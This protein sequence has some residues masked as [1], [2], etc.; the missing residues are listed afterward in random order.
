[1]SGTEHAQF[2]SG[3]ALR[4][5]DRT[6]LAVAVAVALV[7]L[8]ALP[9]TSDLSYIGVSWLMVAGLIGL[10]ALLRRLQLPEAAIVG[11]QLAAAALGSAALAA[12]LGTSAAT[13]PVPHYLGLWTAGIEHMQ[14]QTSPMAP[15]DGVR[16][17]FATVLALAAVVVDAL[18]NALGRPAWSLAPLAAVFAV[19]AVGLGIDTGIASFGCLVAGYAAILVA[20]GLN[21]TRRWP[22]GLIRDSAE[23]F[24]TATPVVW[25]ATAYLML[26][27]LALTVLLGVVLPTLTLPGIGIGPGSGSGGP[28]QLTDP[29]LDLRRNLT[30]SGDRVVIEYQTDAPGGVYLRLATLPRLSS[31]GWGSVPIQLRTGADLPPAPGVSRAI[32]QTPQS[33]SVQVLDFGS[34][35][36]PLPYA[37]THIEVRGDWR[38]DANSL[39][40]INND[41]RPN[42]LRHLAY[43]VES[44]AVDP[45]GEAFAGARPGSPDDADLTAEIPPDL[46]TS[47]IALTRQVT[48]D[49][50][51]PAARAAAIQ[52]FLRSSRFTYSTEQLP[53]TGYGALERF[54]LVDRRGFCEQF[55]GSM[56]MM[57]R[58]AGIPSRVSVGFLPGVR[59]DEGWKVSIRKMHAWPELYFEG[60]GWVRY[61]PTPS[62]VTGPAPRW[63]VDSG[64]GG[65]DEPSLAPTEQPSVEPSTATTDPDAQATAAPSQQ[66]GAAADVAR[67][68]VVVG[69]VV[70]VIALASAPALIRVRRRWRRL[71]RGKPAAEVVED[72]WEEIR[73]TVLDTGGSWP[74]GS[75]RA[76]GAELA[77]RL[78]PADGDRIAHVA[79]LV[80]RARYARGFSDDQAAA[81]VPAATGE[82]RRA[83]VAPLSRRRRISV[84]LLPRSVFRRPGGRAAG[85]SG[86]MPGHHRQRGSRRGNPPPRPE[87]RQAK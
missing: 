78:D 42:A 61:E 75:P 27:A 7:S 37:P 63:T 85:P 19:P 15:N 4:P 51:T 17:I 3:P 31:A 82:L 12:T 29:T 68:L 76:V 87:R 45:Q 47:L 6:A 30:Q 22:R 39:V 57:A 86:P 81:Q 59:D 10:G 55:A 73:D 84:A 64:G 62:L 25:R 5:T 46:P 14:T 38:F 58:V 67:I 40:V 23:G 8:T 56:A 26:P 71:D 70:L 44:A 80:E 21:R 16:L 34:Q 50:Q 69:A 66:P 54:L 52:A 32:T 48:A 24:G 41:S 11:A 60:Y 65:S 9:L 49:A 28:L 83:L 77:S 79:V 43:S 18:V 53:G 35:Y 36:L 72:A 1:M 13:G 74:A 20:D 2:G 33:T